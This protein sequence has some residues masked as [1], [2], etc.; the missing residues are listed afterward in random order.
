MIVQSNIWI[1][2]LLVV[3]IHGGMYLYIWSVLWPDIE[4]SFLSVRFTH[5]NNEQVIVPATRLFWYP[6][7]S[8]LVAL[9]NLGLSLVIRSRERYDWSVR[10]FM[11]HWLNGMTLWLS[12]LVFGYLGVIALKNMA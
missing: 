1:Y 4:N 12:L 2:L 10:R 11:Y 5:L 6:G 7:V 8:L 3:L 9:G